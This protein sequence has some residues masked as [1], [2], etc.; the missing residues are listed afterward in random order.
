ME[1][2]PRSGSPRLLVLGAGPAQLGLL[3][4]A[5]DRGLWVAVVDRDPAR[6]GLPAR[7][8][9]LHPLDRGRAG[10]RAPRRARSG[11]TGSSRPAPTGR[12][13]SPRASPSR[14]GLPHPISPRRPCSRRTSCASGSAWRRRACRSRARG[15]SAGRGAAEVD[16]PVVVK[17]P[18]RQGQKGLTFVADPAGWRRDRDGARRRPQ[19]PR[20]RRGAGGRAGGD[21][22]RLLDRRGLHA[23]AVTD[24]STAE[25]PAFGVALAH[26]WPSSAPPGASDVPRPPWRPGIEN[27]PTL[28][29]AARR[30]GRPEGDRGRGAARRR[31]R[32]GARRGGLG[33]DLNGLALDAALGDG[34]VMTRHKPLVGGAVTRFLV[35]PPGVLQRGRGAGRPRRD[36]PRPDLPGAGLRVHAAPPRGRPGRSGAGLGGSREEA[37]ARANAAADRIRFVTADA[38]ALV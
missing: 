12:S 36:P 17:A 32:R 29:P 19:R 15:S 7:R 33:V 34:P 22:R 27:G 23:T 1:S 20:A 38:G 13:A 2:D 28:H 4:A 3:E 11:S 37:V 14:T 31:P 26:V 25:P 21:G 6:A 10:D 30:P 18:D 24:R 35:A 9:P 5:R 8:P 16:G